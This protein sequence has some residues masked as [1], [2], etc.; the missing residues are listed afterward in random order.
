MEITGLR[1]KIQRVALIYGLSAAA[2]LLTRLLVGE[3]SSLVA[4]I[5]NFVPW[6]AGGA[7]GLALLA[8]LARAPAG[9]IILNFPLLIAFGVLYG[10]QY[11]PRDPVIPPP[12]GLPLTVAT[13]NVFSSG[14]EAT[15][16]ADVLAALE[17]DTV[18]VQELG[19][20]HARVFETRLTAEYPYQALYPL[21]QGFGLGLLSRYPILTSAILL[22][23]ENYRGVPH[24][25]LLRAVIDIDGDP[26]VI[27]VAHPPVPS[28]VS[29]HR[30]H[31]IPLPIVYDDGARDDQLDTVRTVVHNESDPTLV[32]CDCNMTDQSDSYRALAEVLAD[33]FREI[34][35]GLGFTCAPQPMSI[36]AIL[37]LIWRIDYV[38]H[39]Q[40]FVAT[41]VRVGDDNG[42][43]DHHPLI[44]E[45]VLV[46][47]RGK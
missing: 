12:E 16:I 40:Q 43:S 34:G 4:L 6:C 44:A 20:D 17:A 30:W 3:Q 22:T 14:S 11:L 32:L 19:P 47:S 41:A 23:H 27:F 2:Y 8:L 24:L 7:V 35:R 42:T 45:L 18:G 13:Y 1:R 29:I 39:T 26:V 38:W 28:P 5:N 9:V 25:G 10:P 15:P 31:K 37:P 21:D 36:P 46:P 33:T